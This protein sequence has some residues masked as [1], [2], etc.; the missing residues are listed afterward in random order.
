MTA[1]HQPQPRGSGPGH[2]AGDATA[3]DLQPDARVR[4][5]RGLHA[6]ILARGGRRARAVRAGARGIGTQRGDQRRR[7]LGGVRRRPATAANRSPP[8]PGSIASRRSAAAVLALGTC[9]AYGGIPAMRGN[10]TGA[11]GLRDYL[12]TAGARGSGSRS[13]TSPA[14]RSSRT[15]SPRRCCTW[16]CISPAWSRCSTSTSRAGRGGCSGGPSRRAAAAPG[17]PSRA[18]SP[19][20]PADSRGCLVK[21]GCKGPV[22]KCNVPIRGWAGGV[23]G[24]PNVGGICMACT[25]PGFPDRF[26][27]FMEPDPSGSAAAHV[28]QFTYG[29]VLRRLRRRAIAAT[30]SRAGWRGRRP[31]HHGYE[32]R[33]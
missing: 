17:S 2:A 18:S 24:C 7:P 26:M 6:R 23:G 19:R 28:R 16:R 14:A 20:R 32:P 22:V 10:P 1:R 12:G 27:P 3:G 9:A 15:T 8:A 25:M 33:W 13:S 4:V 5:R 31:A 30:S 11:M 29:P 21:L